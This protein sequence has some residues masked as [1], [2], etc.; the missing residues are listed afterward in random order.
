MLD[1]F[2]IIYEFRYLR[3]ICIWYDW[4]GTVLTYYRQYV[5]ELC[6]AR[7]FVNGL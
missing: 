6:T 2:V 3:C 1:S 5:Y 7:M 4:F